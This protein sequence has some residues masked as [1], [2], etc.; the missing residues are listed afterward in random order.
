MR[1]ATM[2]FCFELVSPLYL[3]RYIGQEVVVDFEGRRYLVV[4]S[5]IPRN[6]RSVCEASEIANLLK[7]EVRLW[8]AP[9]DWV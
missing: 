2:V 8:L 7:E 6:H 5:G 1:F 3:E 9:L 4:P